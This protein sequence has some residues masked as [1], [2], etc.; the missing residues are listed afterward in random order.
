MSKISKEMLAILENP[1][2]ARK[3]H[4]VASTDGHAFVED[5]RGNRYVVFTRRGARKLRFTVTM[6]A[7]PVPW[8]KRKLF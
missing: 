5:L 1:V 4:E 8:W 2:S 3:I 6:R 7:A